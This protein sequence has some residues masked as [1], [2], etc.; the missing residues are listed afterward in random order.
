MEFFGIV[1]H[2]VTTW[3]VF[4]SS[5]SQ[6]ML[7]HSIGLGEFLIT[8]RVLETIHVIIHNSEWAIRFGGIL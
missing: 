2:G 8:L 4:G 1:I 3:A 7:A 5:I 6:F